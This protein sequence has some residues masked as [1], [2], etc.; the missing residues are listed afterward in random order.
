MKSKF[1]LSFYLLCLFG[2]ILTCIGIYFIVFRPQLLPED[3]RFMGINEAQ[4]QSFRNLASPWLK[5]VFRVPGGYIITSGVLFIFIAFKSFRKFE[6][7]SWFTALF[8]GITSIGI[9][10]AVNFKIGSD[11]KWWLLLLSLIWISSLILN[12]YEKTNDQHNQG[13]KL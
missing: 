2:F 6:V 11:F 8:A 1:N 12:L 5:Q 10:T 7:W 4:D 3:I 13:E 9:M